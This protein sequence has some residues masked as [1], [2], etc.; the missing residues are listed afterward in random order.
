MSQPVMLWIKLLLAQHGRRSVIAAL[1]EAEDSD[2]DTIER[3]VDSLRERR[4][5]KRRPRRDLDELLED[6]RLDPECYALVKRIGCAY[7]SKRYLSELW[8]VRRFLETHGVDS[9]K[10]RSRTAALPLV[11]D[12]LGGLPIAGLRE[13]AAESE[14]T[15]KGDLRIIADQILGTSETSSASNVRAKNHEGEVADKPQ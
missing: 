13:L 1:A 5:A 8:R 10:I 11:L 7:L 6:L 9:A 3:E 14:G 4:A 15:G 2:F 12:V